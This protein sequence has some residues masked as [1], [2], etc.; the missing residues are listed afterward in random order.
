MAMLCHKVNN[1]GFQVTGNFSFQTNLNH[2]PSRADCLMWAVCTHSPS[3]TPKWWVGDI[4]PLYHYQKQERDFS[5]LKLNKSAHMLERHGRP[6]G[7]FHFMM[8]GT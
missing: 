4:L 5:S 8:T 6:I 7:L 1:D 3:R 2:Q